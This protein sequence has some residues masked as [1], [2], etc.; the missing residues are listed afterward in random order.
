MLL[1]LIMYMFCSLLWCM[2]VLVG[3]SSCCAW[4]VWKVI[5]IVMFGY[6][7]VFL[8]GSCVCMVKVWVSGLV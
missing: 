5:F 2:M 8:F 6:R 3:I 7:L 1:L 4:L